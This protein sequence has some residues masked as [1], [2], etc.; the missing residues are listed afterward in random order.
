MGLSIVLG[1]SAA[2]LAYRPFDGTNADAI[3]RA[4]SAARLRLRQRYLK[5]VADESLE[6]GEG[7]ISK[8]VPMSRSVASGCAA[9]WRAIGVTTTA[10]SL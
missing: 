9:A 8:L 6:A 10:P 7:D 4:C 5:G 2:A 1:P 3:A